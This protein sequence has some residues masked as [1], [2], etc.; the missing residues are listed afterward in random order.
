MQTD[1]ILDQY[2]KGGADT[3]IRLFLYHRE[4]RDAFAR[5]EENDPLELFAARSPAAKGKPGMVRR[6]I[7]ALRDRPGSPEPAA[8]WGRRG[9]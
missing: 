6:I 8:S 2:R 1:Q 5:I 9:R 3:R 7:D 4:L